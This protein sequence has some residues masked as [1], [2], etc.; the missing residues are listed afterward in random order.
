VLSG[1][2]LLGLAA[3]LDVGETPPAEPSKSEENLSP[4]AGKTPE[5]VLLD[6]G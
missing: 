1:G 2:A 3:E 5:E 4:T 6:A